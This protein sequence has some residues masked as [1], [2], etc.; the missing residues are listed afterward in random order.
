LGLD[1]W[2]KKY[3]DAKSKAWEDFFDQ[4]YSIQELEQAVVNM[5]NGMK[6]KSIF[7]ELPYWK[8]LLIANLLDPMHIFKNVLDSIFQHITGK[9]KDTLSSRRDIA[10]SRT[11]F[12]RKHLW[13]SRENE[14]YAEAPWILKKNELDQLENFICSIRTP[15]G[16]G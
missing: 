10:L 16:Y 8:D 5:S 2:L 11:K 13:L 14:T 4:G 6:R 3:E 12:D 1:D 15:T 7:Y 9:E